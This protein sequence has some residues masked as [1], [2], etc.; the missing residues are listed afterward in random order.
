MRVASA[1]FVI[2]LPPNQITIAALP[3]EVQSVIT[4]FILYGTKKAPCSGG[5]V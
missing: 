2:F 1:I 3:I 4:F 5:S